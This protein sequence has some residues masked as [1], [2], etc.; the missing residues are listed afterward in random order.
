MTWTRGIGLLVVA[1]A[2]LI[3]NTALGVGMSWPLPDLA[4]LVALYAGLTCRLSGGAA[5]L[6]RD[7]SPAAMAGLGAAMGYLSDV[8]LGTPR[9]LHA[10]GCALLLLGLRAVARQLLVRGAGF[11]MAACILG[12]LA[13]RL[14]LV[15]VLWLLDPEPAG[16]WTGLRSAFGQALATGLFAPLGFALLSRIDARLWR[17][18]REA[19][20]AAAL[21]RL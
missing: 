4:L 7:A 6:L 9:G 14:L 20:G 13:F 8:V 11:V 2:A 17:D 12:S 5:V 18:P 16:M 21:G 3:I 15:V 19:H 10:L 1:Y